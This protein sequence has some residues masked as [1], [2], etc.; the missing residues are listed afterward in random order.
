ML[1]V[2]AVILLIAWYFFNRNRVAPRGTYD[3][4]N[5]RSSGG[6]GGQPDYDDPNFRSTGSI[7]GSNRPSYDAPDV[8][9]RGSIGGAPASSSRPRAEAAPDRDRPR[10]DSKDFKSGG[11]I[12]G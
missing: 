1:I 8:E 6:I 7:G 4:E 2:I 12:G 9:S 10:H 11:S 5:Y 3:D